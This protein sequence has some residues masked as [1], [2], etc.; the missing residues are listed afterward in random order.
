MHQSLF[1]SGGL[2]TVNDVLVLT[3]YK[4]RTALYRLVRNGIFP[5]PY[6]ISSRQIRWR[7]EDVQT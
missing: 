2:L 1:L 5:N 6:A 3:G 7:A 4:H